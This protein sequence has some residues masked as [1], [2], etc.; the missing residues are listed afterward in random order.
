MAGLE[1]WPN[2]PSG[3]RGAGHPIDHPR[4]FALMAIKSV[5]IGK[6]EAARLLSRFGVRGR[7]LLAF[8]GISG[9]AV[10]AA[11]AAMY[12]FFRV[13]AVLETI[14]ERKIPPA[15][16]SLDLSRQAERIVAVA[17]ALLGA[18]TAAQHEKISK[19]V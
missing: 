1:R 12:S 17:P 19:E 5:I 15:M 13:G 18:T 11:A 16:A 10:L 14:T 4:T 3:Y 8:F 2:F 9:F 6:S 7:L